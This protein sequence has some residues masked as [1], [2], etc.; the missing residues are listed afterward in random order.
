MGQEM[1]EYFLPEMLLDDPFG[2]SL[3]E[4]VVSLTTG[5]GN[6]LPVPQC[7]PAC[8]KSQCDILTSGT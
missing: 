7:S 2:F 4:G 5:F 1:I 8:R 3:D 6:R